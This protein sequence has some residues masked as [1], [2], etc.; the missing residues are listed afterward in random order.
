MPEE[1]EDDRRKREKQQRL[2][3]KA[4]YAN[5]HTQEIKAQHF[6]QYI[7]TIHVSLFCSILGKNSKN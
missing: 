2:V 6:R 1:Q 4:T 5:V 3:I 7:W